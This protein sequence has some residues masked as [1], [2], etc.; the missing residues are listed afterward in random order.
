[1]EP[2]STDPPESSWSRSQT[3]A[4]YAAAGAVYILLG[5]F[6]KEV[7]AWWTYGAAFALIAICGVPSVWRRLR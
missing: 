2:P 7:F 4:A 3:I 6:F 5:S 1:M